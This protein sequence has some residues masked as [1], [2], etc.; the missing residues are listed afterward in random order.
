MLWE[1]E[2]FAG[3]S[4]KSF[5]LETSS[6]PTQN[7]LGDVCRQREHWQVMRGVNP[8]EF[9][10]SLYSHVIFLFPLNVKNSR[11][12]SELRSRAF[13][14]ATSKWFCRDLC[15]VYPY[16]GG[17]IRCVATHL[18]EPEQDLKMRRCIFTHK[19]SSWGLYPTRSVVNYRSDC[20]LP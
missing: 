18:T 10:L 16:F 5:F 4:Q 3:G 15:A 1:E 6:V 17:S 2:V 14:W 13:V 7:Q 20:F 8:S 12:P 11:I 19:E 9:I